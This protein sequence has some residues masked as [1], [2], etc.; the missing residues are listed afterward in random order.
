L[1]NK[2]YNRGSAFERRIKR[3]LEDAGYYVT[4]S[5]GS[6]GPVDLSVVD[7]SGHPYF[8]QCRKDG[9][10]SKEDF[11]KL[12]KLG[13]D[14]NIP[15]ILVCKLKRNEPVEFE[16]IYYLGADRTLNT[17]ALGWEER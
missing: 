6:K 10:L 2:N 9:R 5:G 4:K 17:K 16:N 14:F 12:D 1:P 15:V 3:E 13:K 8:L 11:A 7:R